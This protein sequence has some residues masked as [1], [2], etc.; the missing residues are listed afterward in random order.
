MIDYNNR[1]FRPVSTSANSETSAETVFH[2]KQQGNVISCEYRGGKISSGHLIGLV[3]E[4][5][6]IEMRYHQVNDC[7]ELL[8]G[9]CSS[10]PEILASGKIRLYE[11]W[12]WTCREGSKGQSILEEQ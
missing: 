5:G 2:Y 1:V 8:T 12:Q 6:N 3:G 7:N 11:D 4:N 10:R 9:T